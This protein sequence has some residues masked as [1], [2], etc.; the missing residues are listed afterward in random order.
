MKAFDSYNP[1]AV[2]TYFASVITIGMFCLNPVTMNPLILFL[3]LAGSITT[4]IIRN[5][6]SGAKSHLFFLGMLLLLTLLNPLFNHN[7]VTVLLIINNN[8]ITLEAILYGAASASAI[9]SVIYWF[10]SFSQIMTSDKLLYILGNISPKFALILSMTLRYVPM[11]EN[12]TQKVIQAQRG[13][14]LYSDTDFM[15]RVR[16]GTR[17]FSVMVTWAL[18]NGVI[19]SDSMT[20]RGYGI[21]KRTFFSI[22][23]FRRQDILL[24]VLSVVLFG[25]ILAGVISGS[26][27]FSFYPEISHAE[28]TVISVIT[29]ISYGLLAFLPVII[30]AEEELRWKYLKSKI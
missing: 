24:T 15:S 28:T 25:A 26:V 8:P 13:L 14:G 7:G 19:T 22:F 11:F 3:S 4:F 21:T 5:R 20:A 12:Q 1:I 23:K 2:F 29:Y 18:E 27:N 6:A 9:I 17:V 10:R 30:E 16:G